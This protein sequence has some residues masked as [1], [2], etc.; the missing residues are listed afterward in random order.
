MV[1]WVLCAAAQN[2]HE[3]VTKGMTANLSEPPPLLIVTAG[4]NANVK[5]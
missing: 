3:C 2:V 1:W 5:L 4:K